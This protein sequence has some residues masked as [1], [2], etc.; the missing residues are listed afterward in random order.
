MI[1]VTPLY[2]YDVR[3]KDATAYLNRIMVR[4]VGKLVGQHPL[5]LLGIEQHPALV[6]LHPEHPPLVAGAEEQNAGVV[7]GLAW[8]L[9]ATVVFWFRALFGR[10]FAVPPEVS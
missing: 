7:A 4:N 1:D 10:S 9:V 2:K 3:G 5:E 8:G 6:A